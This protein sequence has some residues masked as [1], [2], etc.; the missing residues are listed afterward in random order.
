MTTA[1]LSS[2]EG[3]MLWHAAWIS[4]MVPWRSAKSLVRTRWFTVGKAIEPH[5]GCPGGQPRTVGALPPHPPTWLTFGSQG[6]G[7]QVL[8]KA[9]EF[10]E[11]LAQRFGEDVQEGGLPVHRLGG[12]QLQVTPTHVLLQDHI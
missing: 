8:S 3:D 6:H 1:N 9:Q 11:V 2:L 7:G 12:V 4:L 10:R 5:G